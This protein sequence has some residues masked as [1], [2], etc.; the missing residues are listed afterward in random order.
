[1]QNL[2]PLMVCVCACVG[3]VQPG[4]LEFV[5]VDAEIGLVIT[6]EAISHSDIPALEA[7]AKLTLPGKVEEVF[8]QTV[9][10]TDTATRT[11]TLHPDD[12]AY[13]LYVPRPWTCFVSAVWPRHPQSFPSVPLRDMCDVL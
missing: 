11:S 4:R 6:D 10:P 12:I 7:M 2:S 3:G 9:E 8:A 1:M 5:A 13:M